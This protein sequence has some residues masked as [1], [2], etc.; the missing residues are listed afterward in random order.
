MAGISVSSP[1]PEP[2]YL[3]YAPLLR[4]KDFRDQVLRKNFDPS[5]FDGGAF[6]TAP[7]SEKMQSMP[8]I[9]PSHARIQAITA[10]VSATEVS[11]FTPTQVL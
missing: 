4:T 10:G 2:E 7:H 11:K 8:P 6:S 1:L 3:R 9:L 5:N